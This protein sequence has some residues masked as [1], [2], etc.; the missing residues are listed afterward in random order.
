VTIGGKLAQI[1]FKGLAPG[2]AGLAQINVIVPD[3]LAPGDQPVVVA[4]NG[5]M[6]NTG[7]ITVK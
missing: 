3:G 5:S 6:S 7:L 4:I 1:V 2:W